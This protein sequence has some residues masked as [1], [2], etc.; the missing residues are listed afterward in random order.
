MTRIATEGHRSHRAEPVRLPSLAARTFAGVVAGLGLAAM[1]LGVPFLLL[2]AF[3]WPPPFP[4]ESAWKYPHLFTNEFLTSALALAA[5]AAWAWLAF[6]VLREAVRAVRWGVDPAHLRD[7]ASPVRWIAG[8]LIGAVA[9]LWPA[10]AHTAPPPPAETT[11]GLQ[12]D[13]D[14]LANSGHTTPLVWRTDT[15]A[16]Q[17]T[18]AGGQPA[19]A[20]VADA[21]AEQATDPA[22]G[23]RMVT[24][25]PDDPTL[26]DIAEKHLGDPMRYNEIFELNKDRHFDGGS[27]NNPARILDGWELLIPDT[28]TAPAVDTATGL[29]VVTVGPGNPTL[30][31]IAEKHLG[32]PMRYMEIYELNKDRT[33]EGG[34]FDNP[35][36]IND[37]WQLL[38][39]DTDTSADEGPAETEA[40][41]AP[42]DGEGEVYEPPTIDPAVPDEGRTGTEEE[43]TGEPDS[44]VPETPTSDAGSERGGG[45]L[46][47]AF[48]F[49]VWLSAGTCLAAGTVLAIALRLRRRRTAPDAGASVTVADE[50]M[51]GRL[52]DLEAVIE[53]EAR[54]LAQVVPEPAT[55]EAPIVAEPVVAVDTDR[56]PV[57]LADLASAGVGLRGPGQRGAARAAILTA[58]SAGA[59]VLVTEAADLRLELGAGAASDQVRFTTGIDDALDT[60]DGSDTM[61]VCADTDLDETTR[62][63]LERFLTAQN[64]GAF[65]LGDWI[66]SS[67]VLEAAG[68]V[69]AAHG[70]SVDA[71]L[72]S[73]HIADLD[74]TAAVLAGLAAPDTDT[75]PVDEVVSEPAAPASDGQEDATGA[76]GPAQHEPG[77]PLLRLCLFG[78]PDVYIGGQPVPLK[79]GRR[80]RAFLTVLACADGPIGRD[81]LL[82][83]VVGDMV[84]ID[85]AKNNFSAVAIDT[86]RALRD[87]TGDT[88]AEFYTYDRASETYELERG[89]FTIDLDE[90]NDADGAAVLATDPNEAAA[91]RE[92]ALALYTADLAPEV[93]TDAVRALRDQYRAAAVRLC[94]QLTEHYAASGDTAL[95]QEHRERGARIAAA[96]GVPAG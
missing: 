24:V 68:T 55:R 85:R 47:A 88:D 75:E 45:G 43:V 34:P 48:P 66:P 52:S 92:A 31:D 91:H 38:L 63:M 73:L 74:T 86:R 42:P 53:T 78:Q 71:K 49:G 16:T 56:A 62:P 11:T 77:R 54:K 25:G 39:P 10:A 58:V 93:D 81:E 41:P 2:A 76:T 95:S 50:V 13:H 28:E 14:D 29:Q 36:E 8:A 80:S 22:T 33:F 82:E 35:A 27:L 9:A 32:D 59:R 94:E 96:G 1:L 57:S 40:P 67:L 46:A 79:K 17:A 84:E 72:R 7:A 60:A 3:G 20:A 19:A 12:L 70:R 65:I 90:F 26:W 87:A 4:S 69:K 51:T 44:T 30:W 83:G 15:V 6:I 64:R 89:R 21:D 5:W 18:T 37:G 61:V 23:L